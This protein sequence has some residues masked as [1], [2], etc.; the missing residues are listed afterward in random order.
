MQ[1]AS[2]AVGSRS[3]HPIEIAPIVVQSLDVSEPLLRDAGF[4]IE[5]EISQN[6]PLAVA[7]PSSIRICIENLLSNVMKYAESGG[8]VKICAR[9]SPTNPAQVE[10]VV[11]DKGSG[12]AQNDLPKI[13]DPFYRTQMARDT[14]ARGVGL[15]L[16]L[17]KRIMESMDGSITVSS[18][19]GRGSRFVLHFPV[20][21]SA[22]RNRQEVA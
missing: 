16:Y 17:V 14:Q 20:E 1:L 2:F 7:D 18:E 6:L 21:T 19:L 22:Q 10:I 8:W 4:I 13:F 5:H 11:E 9:V 15:G 12:I 3:L